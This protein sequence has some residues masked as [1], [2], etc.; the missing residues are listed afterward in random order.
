MS[1]DL[2]DRRAA[3][4]GIL[5]RIL[6]HS[7]GDSPDGDT[8]AV[9]F[10]FAVGTKG[11]TLTQ[12]RERCAELRGVGIDHWRKHLEPKVL[13][14]V[15]SE[16]HLLNRHYEPRL[17]ETVAHRP[18]L[19]DPDYT[20]EGLLRHELESHI[21]K[22]MYGYRAELAGMYVAVRFDAN[23][24]QDEHSDLALWEFTQL[25][26]GMSRYV[27]EYG[28]KLMFLGTEDSIQAMLRIAGWHPPFTKREAN[29]LGL[30]FI[31][32]PEPTIGSFLDTLRST[33]L[34]RNL[35]AKWKEHLVTAASRMPDTP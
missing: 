5:R 19:D 24:D 29:W 25:T 14:A 30:A 32:A 15:A 11:T 2:L 3:L 34:G 20:R 7:F 35:H 6:A 26:L 13:E 18:S 28:E 12:R 31:K 10:G 23:R 27:D 4:D 8:A 33:E 21:L 1:D 22:H 16:L 17:A 9:L